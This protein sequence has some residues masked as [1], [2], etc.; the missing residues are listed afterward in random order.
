MPPDDPVG[1]SRFTKAQL[2]AVIDWVEDIDNYRLLFDHGATKGVTLQKAFTKMSNDLKLRYLRSR[3]VWITSSLA[4]LC[5]GLKT[6]VRLVVFPLR[7]A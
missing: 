4:R 1:S 6:I 3:I 5:F 2:K 7:P